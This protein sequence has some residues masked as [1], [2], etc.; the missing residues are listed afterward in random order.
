MGAERKRAA[1]QG[2]SASSENHQ[3][4]YPPSGSPWW[5][6]T[7]LWSVL[8]GDLQCVGG[9]P[10]ERDPLSPYYTKNMKTMTAVDVTYALK[11]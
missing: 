9:L 8:P 6:K 4:R 5:R 11:S 1:L 10:G 7:Y 3:A 2:K